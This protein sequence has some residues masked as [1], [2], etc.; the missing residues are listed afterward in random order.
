M[1]KARY[2]GPVRIQATINV[3]LEDGAPPEGYDPSDPDTTVPAAWAEI[4][5][6]LRFAAEKEARRI[7]K[8]LQKN[9]KDFKFEDMCDS[10]HI[11]FGYSFAENFTTELL[12][13]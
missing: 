13:D 9:N 5:D 8:E 10:F 2:T 4:E 7:A 3:T 11:D 1:A 12:E 6:R